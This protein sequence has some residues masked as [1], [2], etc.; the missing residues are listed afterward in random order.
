MRDVI[1]LDNSPIAYLFQPENALPIK[2]WFDDKNDTE[3]QQTAAVLEKL[4][5]VEDVRNYIKQFVVDNRLLF[6]RALAILSEKEQTSRN[7]MKSA[8]K[9]GH[10]QSQAELYKARI[11]KGRLPG[12]WAEENQSTD[13][14]ANEASEETKRPLQ[15]VQQKRA[16]TSHKQFNQNYQTVSIT[17][18]DDNRGIIG[19]PKANSSLEEALRNSLY[20]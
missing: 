14:Q 15:R 1:I 17:P 10:S 6:S 16:I 11:L 5:G 4:A 3:L 19:S 20:K 13:F 2:S 8:G 12:Y 18:G 9:I 7:Q